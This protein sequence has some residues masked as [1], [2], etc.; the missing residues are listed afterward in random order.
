M[1]TAFAVGDT[2]HLKSSPATSMTVGRVPSE[3]NDDLLKPQ[4]VEC[5]WLDKNDQVHFSKFPLA[6]IAKSEIPQPI[7]FKLKKDGSI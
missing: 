2:V 3:E 1:Q 7:G 6:M 4:M 5:V